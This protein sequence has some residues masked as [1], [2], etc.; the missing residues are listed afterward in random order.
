MNAVWARI[1]LRAPY[2]L[3][4]LVVGALPV[5][6]EWLGLP[7]KWNPAPLPRPLTEIWWHLPV[8]AAAIFLFILVLPKSFDQDAG[9]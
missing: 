9:W 3:V 2:A 7:T 4:A 8:F 1:R 5:I 6:G